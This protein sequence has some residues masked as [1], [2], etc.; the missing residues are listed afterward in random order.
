MHNGR[1]TIAEIRL[2]ARDHAAALKDFRDLDAQPALE[3]ERGG[4]FRARPER[5][6]FVLPDIAWQLAA[7][8]DRREPRI[9]R[10]NSSLHGEGLEGSEDEHELDSA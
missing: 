9:H 7:R 10:T 1:I 8:R 4:E 3:A 2:A 5:R 6:I